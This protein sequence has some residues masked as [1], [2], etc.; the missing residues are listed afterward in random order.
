MIEN[1]HI[2]IMY[3]SQKKKEISNQ[4]LLYKISQFYSHTKLVFFSCLMRVF[5]NI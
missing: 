3:S 1:L 5:I 2:K 4:E